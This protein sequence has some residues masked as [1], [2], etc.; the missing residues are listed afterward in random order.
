M[1]DDT[2]KG[3]TSSFELYFY[4]IQT[5]TVL[6]C[7][8][9][10]ASIASQGKRVRGLASG[11]IGYIARNA[12]TTGLNEIVVSQTTGSF[13]AGEELIIN[14]KTH[15]SKISIIE[16][17][18][19]TTDDIKSIYQSNFSA[20]I[21]TFNADTVLYDRVLPNFSLSDEINIVG[22][23]ASVA[24]RSFAG[25]GINTGSIVSY[26]KGNYVDPIFN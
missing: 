16:V 23:A 7:N 15:E 17:L 2:Y 25:V 12:G 8:T 1:T 18:K 20:G 24:N 4:D 14:E 3:I 21:S 26:N 11:A 13:I 19:F 22:T 6:K 9:F 10:T 5:F